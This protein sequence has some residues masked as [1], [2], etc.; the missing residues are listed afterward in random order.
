MAKLTILINTELCNGCGICVELCPA[1]VFVIRNG[2]AEVVN[3]D[4]C[5]YCLGCIALCTEKAIV[6]RLNKDW[7]RVW[8]CIER[9]K[10]LNS[11]IKS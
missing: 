7:I 8:R 5:I 4:N 1:E 2:K 10:T 3:A 9:S 11:F 6:I